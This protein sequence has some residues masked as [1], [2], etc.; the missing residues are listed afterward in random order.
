MKY[1]LPTVL[2]VTDAAIGTY[3][4]AKLMERG[5]DMT[6]CKLAGG[7]VAVLLFSLALFLSYAGDRLR[8]IVKSNMHARK[9]GTDPRA[10]LEAY[11]QEIQNT[12]DEVQSNL[13]P[14]ELER[15][16]LRDKMSLTEQ[17]ISS[18]ACHAQ[19]A[20]LDN[21]EE[22]AK[23][24]LA[25]KQVHEQELAAMQKELDAVNG[26]HAQLTQ[27]LSDLQERRT[28]VVSQRRNITSAVALAKARESV[29]KLYDS[30]DAGTAGI[31]MDRI[32][33]LVDT[34]NAKYE[35]T[36]QRDEEAAKITA[37]ERKY[38]AETP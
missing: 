35:L 13:S 27:M 8:V 5:I 19:N 10:M 18:L 12:I 3:T 28:S 33:Q 30:V 11:Q 14:V 20:I 26:I 6:A 9:E 2:V 4:A 38:A 22:E 16:R 23:H 37:L 36:V 32:N 25:A 31:D 29:S 34:M 17:E 1:I 15:S 7:A 21:R 24:Y